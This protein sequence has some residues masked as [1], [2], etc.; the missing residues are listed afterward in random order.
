MVRTIWIRGKDRPYLY[1]FRNSTNDIR[2]PKKWRVVLPLVGGDLDV[3]DKAKPH[4]TP[5]PH[6]TLKPSQSTIVGYPVAMQI[7]RPWK[8]P[9][10]NGRILA[11]AIYASDEMAI[12]ATGYARGPGLRVP[13]NIKFVGFEDFPL[14]AACEVA[15]TTIRTLR[16]KNRRAGFPKCWALLRKSSMKTQRLL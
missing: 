2:R 14:A 15:L 6:R 7:R 12:G 13:Q 11:A 8:R 9:V 3:T 16:Q 4:R 1:S 5:K 10:R